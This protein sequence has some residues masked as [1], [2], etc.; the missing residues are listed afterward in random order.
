L[1]DGAGAA[2][3]DEEGEAALEIRSKDTT[4]W[5]QRP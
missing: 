1:V 5:R 3:A 2:R 4:S